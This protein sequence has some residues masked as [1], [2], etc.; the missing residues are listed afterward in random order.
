MGR[1]RSARAAIDAQKA[2]LWR[3]AAQHATGPDGDLAL[4]RFLA[5]HAGEVFG[6]DAS[7]YRAYSA[8]EDELPAGSPEKARVAA[9]IERWTERWV[10]LEGYTRW[11]GS[12][13]GARG[14]RAVLDEADDVY[15]R[16]INWAGGTYLFFGR[17]APSSSTVKELRRV[18]AAIRAGH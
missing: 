6:L 16:A 12:H 3:E 4:A 8:R 15:N 7:L 9:A 13:T 18:G 11:L 10:A 1:G 2:A 17:A 5:G 14:A